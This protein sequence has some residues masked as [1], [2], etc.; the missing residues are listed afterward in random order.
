MIHVSP[1]TIPELTKGGKTFPSRVVP[2]WW[3]ARVGNVFFVRWC[4]LVA[5][6]AVYEELARMEDRAVEKQEAA[7]EV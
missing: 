5:V 4:P 2:G 6:A 1:L 7:Q 3:E